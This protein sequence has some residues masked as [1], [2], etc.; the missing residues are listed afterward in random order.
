[1]A[2]YV[3][4]NTNKYKAKK[5]TYNDHHYDSKMEA[6]K[7]MEL[8][9]LKREGK[10][11]DWKRQVKVEFNFKLNKENNE[12]ILTDETAGELKAKGIVFRHLFNYFVDFVIENNDESIEYNEQ[13]GLLL[14]PGKTKCFL[15][16]LL[17]ENHPTKYFKMER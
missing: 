11:K 16:S 17:L 3:N 14:E 7:A 8:D 9:Q 6:S 2:Y 15:L 1:M 4:W 13:K 12:W 10:I 5:Q